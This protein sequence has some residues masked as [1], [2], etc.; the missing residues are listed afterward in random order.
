MGFASIPGF[1]AGTCN[2]YFFYDLD[3]ENETDLMIH[4]FAI[5]D[6]TLNDYMNLSPQ[7][8]LTLIKDIVD[9]VKNVN[10]NFISI[11]HNESLNFQDRWAGW[12]NIYEEM[13]KYAIK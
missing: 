4:P 12:E 5:M 11:W 9:E 13:I 6:V 8:S 1:R 10:G 3:L 2:P 7:D